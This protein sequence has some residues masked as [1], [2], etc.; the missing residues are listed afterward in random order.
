MR[1]MEWFRDGDRHHI[2]DSIQFGALLLM[3]VTWLF[4]LPILDAR[5]IGANIIIAAFSLITI[6]ALSI[7]ARSRRERLFFSLWVVLLLVSP[8]L[9]FPDLLKDVIGILAGALLVFVPVRLSAHVL[10]RD[11]VDANTIFG[12]LCAYFF[13]GMSWSVIYEIVLSRA[14]DA[15]AFPEGYDRTFSSSVYFSF[16]TLTTLGYGDI[17]PRSSLARMLAIMEALI[18]QIYLVVIVAK[19]VADHMSRSRNGD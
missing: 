8:A 4:L 17:T 2:G 19:L 11:E 18:G 16:T 7:T 1:F 15:I 6:Q 3:M 13:L 12:A 5:G 14:P 9:E 10:N